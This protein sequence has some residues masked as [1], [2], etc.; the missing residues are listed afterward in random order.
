MPAVA[1]CL[2]VLLFAVSVMGHGAVTEPPPR[3]LG[4]AYVAAC[5]QE[6]RDADDKVGSVS[7]SGAAST[8]LT[9][10]LRGTLR[11]W[12]MEQLP[13]DPKS[14]DL[15]LCKGRQFADSQAKNTIQQYKAGQEFGMKIQIQAVRLP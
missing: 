10:S 14:C 7:F 4:P 5:G 1:R 11:I 9:F 13:H 3:P 8:R 6:I 15:W 12:E 2:P